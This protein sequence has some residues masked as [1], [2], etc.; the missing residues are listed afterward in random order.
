[1]ESSIK[2]MNYKR[3]NFIFICVATA[4]YL[5]LCLWEQ[6]EEEFSFGKLYDQAG[7]TL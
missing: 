6:I 2:K 5:K 3:T 1:M 4:C 7:D